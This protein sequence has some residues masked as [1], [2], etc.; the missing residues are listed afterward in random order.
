[1]M[2]AASYEDAQR[3]PRGTNQTRHSSPCGPGG[4]QPCKHGE[5]EIQEAGF[6][7]EAGRDDQSWPSA[8]T[9]I[10]LVAQKDELEVR[11]FLR[12]VRYKQKEKSLLVSRTRLKRSFR[13]VWM[14]P[15]SESQVQNLELSCAPVVQRM[16]LA[17]PPTPCDRRLTP[18]LMMW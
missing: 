4:P 17:Y 2:K 13:E 3:C 1:M 16:E 15:H 9:E 14:Q 18:P 6:G 12:E 7:L 5:V 11:G 8:V 10:I